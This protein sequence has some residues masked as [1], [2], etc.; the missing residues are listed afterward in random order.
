MGNNASKAL[1]NQPGDPSRIQLNNDTNFDLTLGTTTM[2][3]E[4]S[5]NCDNKFLVEKMLRETQAESPMCADFLGKVGGDF[6]AHDQ[7]KANDSSD[8]ISAAPGF[9]EF[10][11]V[12]R[13]SLSTDDD[14]TS[15]VHPG[16][17]CDDATLGDYLH[18][19]A[20]NSDDIMNFSLLFDDNQIPL[21]GIN[22]GGDTN[23]QDHCIGGSMIQIGAACDSGSG[24]D[25]HSIWSLPSQLNTMQ[26]QQVGQSI[27]A[28]GG[29]SAGVQTLLQG[30][31]T[32]F[33]PQVHDEIRFPSLFIS[34]TPQ[35]EKSS[36]NNG[37]NRSRISRTYSKREPTTSSQHVQAARN[38]VDNSV[39][40]SGQSHPLQNPQ[41]YR[42]YIRS[43]KKRANAIQSGRPVETRTGRFVHDVTIDG[44]EDTRLPI[45]SSNYTGQE[46]NRSSISND[47]G[48]PADSKDRLTAETFLISEALSFNNNHSSMINTNSTSIAGD[49]L[50]V[51]Q[52]Q[53]PVKANDD[54]S[55]NGVSSEEVGNA[56]LNLGFGDLP[57][58][59]TFQSNT[60]REA[61]GNFLSL[62]GA[63]GD[64]A[65]CN[66]LGTIVRGTS[67][68][69]SENPYM[70]F[71]GNLENPR[72]PG[73]VQR[74]ISSSNTGVNSNQCRIPETVQGNAHPN[75]W[76][77]SGRT[78]G[79][80][81]N[82][83]GMFVNTVPK[84]GFHAYPGPINSIPPGLHT[85]EQVR[86][87]N[88]AVGPSSQ[89]R[90]PHRSISV[91]PQQ[92][93]MNYVGRIPTDSSMDSPLISGAS[94]T[95]RQG[96]SGNPIL[97]DDSVSEAAIGNNLSDNSN[98][99]Q[100]DQGTTRISRRGKRVPANDIQYGQSSKVLLGPSSVSGKPVPVARRVSLPQTPEAL[101]GHTIP[102]I[103][104]PNA[105]T[106][107]RAPR[108]RMMVPQY[109]MDSFVPYGNQIRNLPQPP[110]N[111]YIP[112]GSQFQKI[113]QQ[114]SLNPYSVPGSQTRR[115]LPSK[116]SASRPKTVHHIKWGGP[117]EV[118]KSSG[119]K[120]QI[121]KRDVMYAA[122]GAFTQPE[123][124]PA[125]AVLPCG[126]TFH[127][128]CLQRITP[129][130]QLKNPPCI[131]CAIGTC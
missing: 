52:S 31:T 73:N 103:N 55:Y 23:V 15:G 25:D 46:I 76:R 98:Q 81:G 26:T 45:L 49:M 86:L 50:K 107:I 125:V 36:T 88:V 93:Y 99:A 43:G 101:Y 84:T 110:V 68:G 4:D 114:P 123:A 19:D 122:T 100:T 54:L 111:Q 82:G 108:P 87:P 37:N 35:T 44:D 12:K 11:Q 126:H 96:Q 18:A 21:A 1:E 24:M 117:R 34:P 106:I 7:G 69:A 13:D 128:E 27:A 39:S 14:V 130:D 116:V 47:C 75:I 80:G 38:S 20:V 30:G 42:S 85:N 9:G 78:S 48:L 71:G 17:P 120:C 65:L 105:P 8:M 22:T 109:P 119:E 124:P 115:V 51:Q 5:L 58:S 40:V 112:P 59:S 83:G 94:R 67:S 16:S 64:P 72:W 95:S 89:T 60:H 66:E 79:S 91:T 92:V 77:P 90:F 29:D 63:L 102:R 127:D 74:T 10:P 57:C 62:G 129:E 61:A 113:A 121:C 2:D 97:I 33:T 53:I 41:I 6:Q 70:S 104:A 28:T 118:V 56:Y 131:P 3:I 32:A